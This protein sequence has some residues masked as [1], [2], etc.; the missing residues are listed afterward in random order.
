MVSS[1]IAKPQ[2]V[3]EEPQRL[4]VMVVSGIWTTQP[5][6]GGV[7]RHVMILVDALKHVHNVSV[8]IPSWDQKHLITESIDEISVF[9]RRLAVAPKSHR[10]FVR[11][12]VSW[13][14]NLPGTLI[15]LRRVIKKKRIDVIHLHQVTAGSHFNFWLLRKLG[16]PPYVVGLHGRETRDYATSPRFT[17]W[18]MSKLLQGASGG[19]A[20]S[21][22]LADLGHQNGWRIH[23]LKVIPSGADLS[24]VLGAAANLARGIRTIGDPY[25]VML[26]R[27]HEVKGQDLAVDAWQHLRA[28]HPEVH[29]VLVGNYTLAGG[30]EERVEAIGCQDRIHL[31]GQQQHSTAL[32]WLKGASGLIQASRS[33]GG[34]APF[35]ILEAAALGVP[36]LVSGIPSLLEIIKD[37]HNGIVFE[38][39]NPLAIAEAVS[40]LL[41]DSDLG[42]RISENLARKM[43]ADLTATAMA[44]KHVQ[45]FRMAMSTTPLRAGRNASIL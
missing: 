29:L 9:R 26:G 39:K 45:V 28:R 31:L 32:T 34:C 18:Q 41:E 30:Y 23:N 25:F 11:Q 33:E 44:E 38:P 24:R 43:R 22:E 5:L 40:R 13:L 16:G 19:V 20:V 42:A 15:A 21:R 37:G 6:E 27:L 3:P 8:F 4:N 12:L 36:V 35:A 10:R 14:I 7:R 1:E 17:C 2:P